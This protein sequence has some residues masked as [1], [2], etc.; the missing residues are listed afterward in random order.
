MKKAV[1]C[2]FLGILFIVPISLIIGISKT[3]MQQYKQDDIT[4]LAEGAYGGISEVV[5]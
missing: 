1:L 5:K 2:I 3:E 4:I